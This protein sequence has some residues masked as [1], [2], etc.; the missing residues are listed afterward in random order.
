MEPF[1]GGSRTAPTSI[2]ALAGLGYRDGDVVAGVG[3]VRGELGVQDLSRVGH[4]AQFGLTGRHVVVD[5]RFAVAAHQGDTDTDVR[6]GFRSYLY[7]VRVLD[8]RVGTDRGY[9][10]CHGGVDGGTRRCA[11]VDGTGLGS[12]SSCVV[13]DVVVDPLWRLSLG[14]EADERVGREVLAPWFHRGEALALG[15]VAEPGEARGTDR[16]GDIDLSGLRQH[17]VGT[18]IVRVDRD[19]AL[20]RVGGSGL[21]EHRDYQ[22]DHT[23]NQQGDGH[24]APSPEDF[25]P[26]GLTG[27]TQVDEVVSG[28]DFRPVRTHSPSGDP[29][30]TRCFPPIPNMLGSLCVYPSHTGRGLYRRVCGV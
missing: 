15:M 5:P 26:L 27:L 1:V 7:D 4:G 10:A 16:G 24:K 30:E 3:G 25:A 6:I 2:S 21:Y 9:R 28:T 18:R 20:C 13:H 14:E 19:R 17:S 22:R 29:P 23:Q 12:I 8:H 11:D